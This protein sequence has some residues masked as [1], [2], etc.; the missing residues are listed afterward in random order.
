MDTI[1]LFGVRCSSFLLK[2]RINIPFECRYS[3]LDLNADSFVRNIA[4][5]L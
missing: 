1:H 4:I 5:K 3:V 2:T